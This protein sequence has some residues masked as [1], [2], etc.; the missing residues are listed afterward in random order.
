MPSFLSVFHARRTQFHP[1]SSGNDPSASSVLPGVAP[2]PL[3]FGSRQLLPLRP[4]LPGFFV[5]LC[6]DRLPAH[7]LPAFS[8][9]PLA[10][11]LRS[12][13]LPKRFLHFRLHLFIP[14]P[15]PFSTRSLPRLRMCLLRPVASLPLAPLQLTAHRARRSVRQPHYFPKRLSLLSPSIYLMSPGFGHA[16]VGG[17]VIPFPSEHDTIEAEPC[18]GF[19]CEARCWSVAFA[20]SRLSSRASQATPLQKSNFHWK[21]V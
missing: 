1:P 17:S 13:S 2:A 16:S 8:P 12:P 20:G 3:A 4:A 18:R 14:L 9:G 19:A 5:G 7:K 15:R 10:D 11:Y 21:L 6:V